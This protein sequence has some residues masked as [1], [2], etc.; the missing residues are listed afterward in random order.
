MFLN[1]SCAAIAVRN[2]YEPKTPPHK[3]FWAALSGF[4]AALSGFFAGAWQAIVAIATAGGTVGSWLAANEKSG[5][6]KLFF[7]G[8]GVALLIA[9]AI[10]GLWFL[11][12]IVTDIATA[13]G[14]IMFAIP[15]YWAAAQYAEKTHNE[16]ILLKEQIR[17]W[18]YR[19]ESR[20]RDASRAAAV[21]GDSVV[22]TADATGETSDLNFHR[23]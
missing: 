4:W 16:N 7:Q 19:N 23:R 3:G 9:T 12:I 15:V 13:L 8:L 22:P 21:A 17:E 1:I 5:E 10:M 14:W 2:S 20:E 11:T 18:K 6:S